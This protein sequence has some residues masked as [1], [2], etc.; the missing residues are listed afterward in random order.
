MEF[1]AEHI[2][3]KL[4]LASVGHSF[5]FEF[6]KPS[7]NTASVSLIAGNK[8][9]ILSRVI[10]ESTLNQ[11]TFHYDELDNDYFIQFGHRITLSNF[12]WFQCQLI[13]DYYGLSSS[14]SLLEAI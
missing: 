9:I 7:A 14:L 4:V 12:D 11:I 10:A 8:D 3:G 2:N 13:R 1:T 6:S 5:R